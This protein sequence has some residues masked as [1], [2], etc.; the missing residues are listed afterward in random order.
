MREEK[1]QGGKRYV[2]REER[3]EGRELDERIERGSEFETVG[4]AQKKDRRP[5]AV[6]T[7]EPTRRCLLEDRDEEERTGVTSSERQ[8][9]IHQKEF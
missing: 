5:L 9:A 8:K 2:S 7:N 4:A 1:I 6:F 3:K